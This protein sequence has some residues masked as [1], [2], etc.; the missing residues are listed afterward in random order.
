MEEVYIPALSH[1][2]VHTEII[3]QS[4]DVARLC[5]CFKENRSIGN[6]LV[7]IYTAAILSTRAVPSVRK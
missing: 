3:A 6:R 2:M 7:S 1:C 4:S 5:S